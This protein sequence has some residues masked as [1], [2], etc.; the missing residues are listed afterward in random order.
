MSAKQN[1]ILA[2]SEELNWAT[3]MSRWMT[4]KA[5][6]GCTDVPDDMDDPAL[7]RWIENQ[8]RDYW[9]W[10]QGCKSIMEKEA[11]DMLGN[12]GFNWGDENDYVNSNGADEGDHESDLDRKPAATRDEDDAT[13][14]EENLERKP[15]ARK[16]KA[17]KSKNED[18]DDFV[19]DD[20][21]S[22]PP[23]K[24]ARTESAR[25]PRR[26]SVKNNAAT[27]FEEV[28]AS[29][30]NMRRSSK[31]SVASTPKGGSKASK[32]APPKEE[33]ELRTMHRL[34][35]IEDE[36]RLFEEVKE[37]FKDL[38]LSAEPLIEDK[39]NGVLNPEVRVNQAFER[40]FLEFLV[41]RKAYG[42][43]Y[44]P[45]I[46]PENPS[47]G[48]W[49][50]KIRQWKNTGN[51]H[52]TESRMKRLEMAGFV[53]N[54]KADKC[55][56][57]LQAE[58]VQATELWEEMFQE[59]LRYKHDHGGSC[60]VPK[61][62]EENKRLARWVLKQRRAHKAKHAG[63]YHTLDDEREQRL[64]DIGFVFNSRTPELMRQNVFDRF[65]DKWA[66]QIEKLRQFKEVYG[67]AAVPRRWKSDPKLSSWAMRQV[68]CQNGRQC[69]LSPFAK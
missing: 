51:G 33:T 22:S 28:E 68:F 25:R 14:D 49:C 32:R 16:M 62:Y 42:H 47:L 43:P 2:D 10:K 52:L 39:E 40:Q 69:N 24:L 67:H 66:E 37:E 9:N 13:T 63:E 64:I 59:L 31:T 3:G 34:V 18:G 11:F 35:P 7:I 53:W 8:R 5:A 56:W 15:R 17:N 27:T 36:P 41:F 30:K 21:E 50:C 46:F 6:G 58:C 55:F 65:K 23:R 54:P 29:R 44:V 1:K 48:R 45:K 26:E 12:F 19:S 4:M 60:L 57:R 38:L 61:E 20:D